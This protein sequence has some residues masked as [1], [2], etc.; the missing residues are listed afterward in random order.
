M[1]KYNTQHM[2]SFQPLYSRGT[3]DGEVMSIFKYIGI[4]GAVHCSQSEACTV[5]CTMLYNAD[6]NNMK[7]V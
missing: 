6:N 5:L 2:L 7:D 3:S 1:L 4:F